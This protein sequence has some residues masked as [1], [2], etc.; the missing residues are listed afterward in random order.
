MQSMHKQNQ[1]HFHHLQGETDLPNPQNVTCAN[2]HNQ[3]LTAKNNFA[4]KN[5][6][7]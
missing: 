3:L 7:L 4:Q 6:H 2:L 5:S 1:Q